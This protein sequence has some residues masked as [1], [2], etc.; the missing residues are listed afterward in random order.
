MSS[1]LLLLLFFN[2]IIILLLL[3]KTPYSHSIAYYSRK[4]STPLLMSGFEETSTKSPELSIET[5]IVSYNPCEN[6]PHGA[7]SMPIY[8]TATF[9]QPGATTFGEYDYTRSGNPTRDALQNQIASLGLEY[10]T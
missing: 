5:R 2:A 6:D 7:T 1:Q 9:Q 3:F 8:Q 4:I 10:T